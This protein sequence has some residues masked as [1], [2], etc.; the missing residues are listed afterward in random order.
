M[1][2]Q[3]VSTTAT[4]GIPS[5][6]ASA[7]AIFSWPTSIMN[8]MSGRAVMSLIPPRLFSSFSISRRSCR[9]SF[10]FSSSKLPSS[11]WVSRSL[12]RLMDCFTVLKLVSIPPS[13]RWVT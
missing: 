10:L 8:R 4:T 7:S 2:E 1:G 9:T 12:R 5:L 13:Q 6:L 11:D 3:L